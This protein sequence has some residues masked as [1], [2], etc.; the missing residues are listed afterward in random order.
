MT[1]YYTIDRKFIRSPLQETSEAKFILKKL[2]KFNNFHFKDKAVIIDF[3][4]YIYIQFLEDRLQVGTKPDHFSFELLKK[5]N[6]IVIFLD[7]KYFSISLP[8]DILV[9]NGV[10]YLKSRKYKEEVLIESLRILKILFDKIIVEE[11]SLS[12]LDYAEYIEDIYKDYCEDNGIVPVIPETI[13]K[14][15]VELLE[16]DSSYI[17][18]D[19]DFDNCKDDNGQ[20]SQ[21]RFNVHPPYHFDT[22]FRDSVS[23]K[24]GIDSYVE[25]DTFK[26]IFFKD[27]NCLF[28]RTGYIPNVSNFRRSKNDQSLFPPRDGGY[29]E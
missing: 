19:S 2:D 24:I 17:R 28:I 15:L 18:F 9:R 6:R 20:M 3:L 16:H 1:R 7:E 22:D 29:L 25:E 23:F 11:L 21:E 27:E 5:Q 10:N 4:L 13:E 26:K 8:F 12:L 14:L